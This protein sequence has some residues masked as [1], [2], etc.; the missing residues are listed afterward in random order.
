MAQILDD[1][2]PL[3][4]SLLR[5]QLVE[6]IRNCNVPGGDVGYALKFAQEQLGPRAPVNPQ[7]LQDLEKTMALLLI[8]Q[9]S[10][11][12]PL[13]ALLDPAL[14]RDAADRVNKAIIEKHT[15]R[16]IAGIRNLV[17]MRCWAETNARAASVPFPN[18]L[19][20]GLRG[21]DV[22]MQSRRDVETESGNGNEAMV[23]S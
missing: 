18:P 15:T 14:R 10:L 11:E 5:L 13:A 20:I 23:T 4:F 1:D 21:D 16:T 12:A 9:E 19:D 2:E 8:P 3:H 7:F 22:S 6:L 17:K